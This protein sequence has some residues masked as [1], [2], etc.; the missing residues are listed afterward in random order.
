MIPSPLPGQ[1]QLHYRDASLYLE[2]RRLS[3]LAREHGTPLYVYSQA[4][5]LQAL[6]AYQRGFAGRKV[7]ICY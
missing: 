7:Q 1:P 6:A 5:M 4:A 3:D 2:D